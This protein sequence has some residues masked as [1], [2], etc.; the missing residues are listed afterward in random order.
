MIDIKL[1][2][3]VSMPGMVIGT[4]WMGKRELKKFSTVHS[5]L[6]SEQLIQPVIMEMNRL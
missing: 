3:G 5:T 1:T 6:D 4:N 2:N